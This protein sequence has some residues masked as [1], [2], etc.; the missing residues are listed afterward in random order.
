MD[1]KWGTRVPPWLRKPPDRGGLSHTRSYTFWLLVSMPSK[2]VSQLKPS[3]RREPTIE[4]LIMIETTNYQPYWTIASLDISG[5]IH[6]YYC[7]ISVIYPIFPMAEINPIPSCDTF[8]HVAHVP[9]PWPS[10][11]IGQRRYIPGTR[12]VPG[13]PESDTTSDGRA[14]NICHNHQR[15]GDLGNL[16]W[17]LHLSSDMANLHGQS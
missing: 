16:K 17:N 6:M 3:V 5:Y 2:H 4:T 14:T 8:P 9:R 7:V 11:P 15:P 1:D 13:N 10:R 12:G